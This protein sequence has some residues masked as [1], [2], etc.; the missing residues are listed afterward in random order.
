MIKLENDQ[1]VVLIEPLMGGRVLSVRSRTTAHELLFQPLAHHQS[2]VSGQNRFDAFAYG[3]DDCFPSV[4]SA[5][6]DYPD[7]GML[8][9]HLANVISQTETSVM[10]NIEDQ[11]WKIKKCFT[12]HFSSIQVE[13]EIELLSHSPREAFLTTHLLARYEK[14]MR[15][16]PEIPFEDREHAPKSNFTSGEEMI[17]PLDACR[18]WWVKPEAMSRYFPKQLFQCGILYPRLGMKYSMGWEPKHFPFLGLWVTSGEFQG[19]RNL[20]WE[21][22]DGYFDSLKTAQQNRRLPIF[23]ARQ[24]KHFAY[25]ISWES[26]ENHP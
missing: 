16:F 20:A 13:L 12:L 2:P 3:W 5:G 14:G 18:K 21:I 17:G 22:S 15:L 25:R 19:D 24:I 1:L 10:L 7:H 6:S 8:W 4:I 9:S 26:V 11:N 23:Q